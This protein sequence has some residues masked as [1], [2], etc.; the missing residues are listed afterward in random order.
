MSTILNIRGTNGSGKSTLVRGLMEKIGLDSTLEEPSGKV[1]GYELRHNI[2]VLGRYETQCGGLDAI[3]ETR[4]PGQQGFYNTRKGIRLLA[5]MGHVICEG[6][7][8]STVFKSSDLC[9]KELP[10]HHFIFAMVDTPADVCIER[11]QKRRA[12]KGNQ[13]PFNP[14]ELLS[15][16]EQIGRRQEDLKKAGYDVRSIPYMSALPTVLKWLEDEKIIP[17]GA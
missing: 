7:L 13:K 17:Y 14:K 11:V 1:W 15:K 2:R 12:E 4:Q 3:K 10:Q 8:W 9:A 5:E 6:V 16:I